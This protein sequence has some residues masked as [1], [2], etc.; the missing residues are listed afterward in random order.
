MSMDI[1]DVRVLSETHHNFATAKAAPAALGTHLTQGPI[2]QYDFNLAGT[3]V[4]L[5]IGETGRVTSPVLLIGSSLWFGP[6]IRSLSAKISLLDVASTATLSTDV[7]NAE[8]VSLFYSLP[9]R[10]RGMSDVRKAR[11]R[12]H[13]VIS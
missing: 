13:Q 11:G 1:L 3:E 12:L 9:R 8:H 7:F 10:F 5:P 4:E 2:G 6:T